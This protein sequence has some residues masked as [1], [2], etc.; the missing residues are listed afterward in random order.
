MARCRVDESI[1]RV[2][3]DGFQFPLGVYPIEP[4]EPQQGYTVDFEP[5]DGDDEE[6]EWEEWPDRY[7]YDIVISA[8]RVEALCRSLIAMLPGRIYPI[9]DVLGQDYWREI[10]PYISYDLVGLERFTDALRRFRGYFFEDGLV[11]FGAMS[12]DPFFYFFVDEHKIVTVRATAEFK[13]RVE[14]VLAAFDLEQTDAAAGA[15]AVSHEHRGV[16]I[17]PD[18]RPDLLTHEEIIEHLRDVWRLTLNIDPE[19]NVDEEGNDLGITGWR[20]L[21]RCAVD[22]D[23]PARYAEVFLSAGSLNDAEDMA[24]QAAED[25]RPAGVEGWEE[26]MIV[27]A[28]RMPIGKLTEM[29]AAA[30]AEG[31]SVNP[32]A[33]GNANLSEEGT[34]AVHWI[35]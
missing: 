15:D 29:I 22:V 9:L 32:D 34:W 33:T 35:E 19:T 16:L 28:D 5:S 8:D 27:N 25:Q 11:G 14:K 30:A 13:E 4:M 23:G 6:G 20:C 7:V 31:A 17:A 1:A 3:L 10:D 26:T 24:E 18:D 12:V 21:V 2:V